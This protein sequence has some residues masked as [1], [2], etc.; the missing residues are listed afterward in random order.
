M[1]F[2]WMS[3]WQKVIEL[4]DAEV[5]NN[6][7]FSNIHLWILWMGKI[8]NLKLK[9]A[10][11]QRLKCDDGV[12]VRKKR[13]L[14]RWL[15]PSSIDFPWLYEMVNEIIN[16]TP[17]GDHSLSLSIIFIVSVHYYYFIKVE[18][19]EKKPIS[20]IFTFYPLLLGALFWSPSPFR[21]RENYH[22]NSKRFF[23]FFWIHIIHNNH[24][25]NWTQWR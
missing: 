22:I 24:K 19:G 12:R 9:C 2:A 14:N 3:K 6:F 15:W 20:N 10:I 4:E 8:G 13:V 23:P 17:I 18:K 7:M 25:K 5:D 11:E 21:F 16:H 1:V